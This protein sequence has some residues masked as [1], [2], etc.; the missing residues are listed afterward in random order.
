MLLGYEHGEDS[1]SPTVSA[2]F[3][4]AADRDCGH[5]G[6]LSRLRVVAGRWGARPRSEQTS[7]S[8]HAQLLADTGWLGAVSGHALDRADVR[9]F[10]LV[11]RCSWLLQIRWCSV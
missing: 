9:R 11:R 2:S 10:S 1:F 3:E 7:H 6:L 4:M 5:A 8:V